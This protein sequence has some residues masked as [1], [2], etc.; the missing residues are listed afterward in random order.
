MKPLFA[1]VDH[2][3]FDMMPGI[4]AA[5]DNKTCL[6]SVRWGADNND[7]KERKLSK[8]YAAVK[9][10]SQE[11]YKFFAVNDQKG[12][13]DSY[14]RTSEQRANGESSSTHLG[15]EWDVWL[16]TAAVCQ[17]AIIVVDTDETNTPFITANVSLEVK[18]IQEQTN[19]PSYRMRGYE[20][21]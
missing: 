19:D 2:V 21:V 17:W 4:T 16:L 7:Q 6:V 3:P 15:Q 12:A 10:K 14:Q 1:N 8:L 13:K 5:R 18:V 9:Q 11:G 20:F